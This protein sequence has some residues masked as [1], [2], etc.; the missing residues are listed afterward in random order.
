MVVQ[1]NKDFVGIGTVG[2]IQPLNVVT[3]FIQNTGGKTHKQ[4]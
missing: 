2:I 4:K 1:W 3:A